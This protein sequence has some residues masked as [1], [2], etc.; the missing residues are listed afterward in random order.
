M[1]AKL[2]SVKVA[3]PT[4]RENWLNITWEVAQVRLTSKCSLI[5]RYN[6]MRSATLI[7]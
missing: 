4:K 7:I 6:K 3:K 5:E 2:A 1:I